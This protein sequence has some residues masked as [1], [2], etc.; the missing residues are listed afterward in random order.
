MLSK[1]IT[2]LV[3]IV[4]CEIICKVRRICDFDLNPAEGKQEWRVKEESCPLYC[5][6]LGVIW[7]LNFKHATERI[8]NIIYFGAMILNDLT[9]LKEAAFRIQ[10]LWVRLQLNTEATWTALKKIKLWRTSVQYNFLIQPWKDWLKKILQERVFHSWYVTGVKI[11]LYFLESPG[12]LTFKLQKRFSRK[13]WV[14]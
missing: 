9:F 8:V 10:E 7:A 13:Y 3:R 5:D 2:D 11:V 14:I 1:V 6:G 4:F 12:N